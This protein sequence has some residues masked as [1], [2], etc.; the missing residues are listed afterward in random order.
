ME[1]KAN[2]VGFRLDGGL[3][4]WYHKEMKSKEKGGGVMR[5]R[6]LALLLAAVMM[7]TLGA[8]GGKPDPVPE[9]EPE[10]EEEVPPPEPEP[11]PEPY[12]PA[13]T[14]PL[15]GLPMEPE[16]QNRRPIAIMLNNLKAAQPQ[17]GISQADIIY[18]VP[19]EGGI[20]RMLCLYQTVEGVG[21][22]GSVRSARPYFVELALGHDAIYVHAGGSQEAYSNLRSWKVDHMDGVRGGDDAQIF[23]RDP[24]RRKNNGYE[25]SLITSDEKILEY[26]AKGKIAA[27]HQ[28]GWSSPQT[29]VEDGTP[30]GGEAAEHIKV[31]FSNY[32]TGGFDYDAASGKY[33]VSQY[34]KAH[35]DGA[36]GEQ[37]SAVNVLVLKTTTAVLDDVGRLRVKTIGE[38]EG[39]FFCG[40]R[41]VPIRWSREDRNSAFVYTLEDGLTPLALGQGNSYVCIISPKTS[42][43]EYE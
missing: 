28:D 10:P 30:A 11:E 42:T 15:T 41:A 27:E 22:L 31:R 36:S 26:L 35:I 8:C 2:F 24:D 38:G 12:V 7:M 14:N 23:W 21:I 32:K 4:R 19:V 37:V 18:E 13:G 3:L 17:L 9:P 16:D 39:I 20:T 25:H 29:F 1:G 33:L 43:V 6:A 5:K 34:G 40:G